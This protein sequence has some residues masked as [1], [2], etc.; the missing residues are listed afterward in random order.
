MLRPAHVR[1]LYLSN[2]SPGT[3]D[4]C[5]SLWISY[6]RVLS[7]LFLMEVVVFQVC[8]K[9]VMFPL[10]PRMRGGLYYN[11]YVVSAELVV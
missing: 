7:L 9:D 2:V 10:L 11:S 5:L 1:D 3:L 8:F 4:V 6:T